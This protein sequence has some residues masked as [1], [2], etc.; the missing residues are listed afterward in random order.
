LFS[1]LSTENNKT[2]NLWVLC[3]WFIVVKLFLQIA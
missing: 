2:N 1:V 3:G